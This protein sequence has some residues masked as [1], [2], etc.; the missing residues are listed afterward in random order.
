MLLKEAN[1]LLDKGGVLQFDNFTL[2]ISRLADERIEMATEHLNLD[3][4]KSNETKKKLIEI[5]LVD[6][7][8]V[9]LT[10]IPGD[11]SY[12]HLIL[13]LEYLSDEIGIEHVDD[14]HKDVKSSI[15]ITFSKNIGRN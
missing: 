1:K 7:R 14:S 8:K 6:E 13:Y 11:I 3:L 15:V 10:N 5:K 2:N 4:N 9:L 12:E